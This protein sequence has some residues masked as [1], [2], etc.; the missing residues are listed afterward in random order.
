MY[1]C[2][3]P[4]LGPEAT[5]VAVA[6]VE[7]RHRLAGHPVELDDIRQT[8]AVH[9]EEE[10]RSLGRSEL[11]NLLGLP[12][13]ALLVIGQRDAVIERDGLVLRE[14][15]EDEIDLPIRVEVDR[16]DLPGTVKVA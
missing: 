11:A 7:D 1:D 12:G 15:R 2:H 13:V 10:E 3:A 9:V 8:V 14:V 16:P 4:D 5:A 6:G